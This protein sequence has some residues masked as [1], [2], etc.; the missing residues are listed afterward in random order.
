M[1]ERDGEVRAVSADE[2]DALLI[3]TRTRSEAT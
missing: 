3:V 2:L 1:S